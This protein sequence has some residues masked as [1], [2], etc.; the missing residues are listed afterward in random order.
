VDVTAEGVPIYERQAVERPA[1]LDELPTAIRFSAQSV[2]ALLRGPEVPS[3]SAVGEWLHIALRLLG[4][5]LLGL[6]VLSVR[7][8]VKR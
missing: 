8:R 2:T 7:G 5:V 6:A 3:L 1:G 4:P